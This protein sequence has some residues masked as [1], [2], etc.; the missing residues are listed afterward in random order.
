MRFRD[1]IRKSNE[2][3]PF[4]DAFDLIDQMPMEFSLKHGCFQVAQQAAENA[5]E[6]TKKDL[7]L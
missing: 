3:K 5:W 2:A 6:E 7:D 1:W 4:R